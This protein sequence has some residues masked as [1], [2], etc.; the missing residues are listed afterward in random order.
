MKTLLASPRPG[1]TALRWSG[2]ASPIPPLGLASIA[3]CLREA[4][5]EVEILDLGVERLSGRAL[6]RR[7]GRARARLVGISIHTETRFESFALAR[8]V[9]LASP[10]AFI[11][12]GGPHATLAP[13]ETLTG[14][15]AFDAAV[16]GEGEETLVELARA[17]ESGRPVSSVRGLAFLEGGRYAETGRREGIDPLD[18]LPLP[19]RDLLPWDR[20][21]FSFATPEGERLPG[22]HLVTSRGCPH[23]CEFCAA[24]PLW[25]RRVR[26]RSAEKVIEELAEL[27][28]RWGARAFWFYDDT[29][30][31][32]RAR[33]EAIA[34]GMIESKLVRPWFCEIRAEG[35]D[36]ELLSLMREAGCRRVGLG[37]ESA[38][39]ELVRRVKG[40][41]ASVERSREVLAW[42]GELGIRAHP[43]FILSLPGETRAQ[44]EETLA[45]AR[46]CRAEGHEPAVSVLHVYPGTPLEARA[47]ELGILAPGFRWSDPGARGAFLLPGAQGNVPVW[48]DRLPAAA[49]QEMLGRYARALD[50]P[51]WRCG[52]RALARGGSLRPLAR[53]AAGWLGR[54]S[55]RPERPGARRLARAWLDARG[56]RERASG[57]PVKL[58]VEITSRCNLRCPRCPQSASPPG[59][60]AFMDRTLYSR[61]LREAM[62]F[63]PRVAL[64]HRGE[65]LLHPEALSMIAEAG[66]RGLACVLH[67][68]ATT[69]DREAARALLASG[70]EEISVSFDGPGRER[71]ERARAGASYDEVLANVRALLDEAARQP[72][73]DRPRIAVES[74]LA[75]GDAGRE[76]RLARE[77]RAE[78]APGRPDAVRLKAAHNWAGL[79]GGGANGR[80]RSRC[81]MPWTALVVLASGR[82]TACPQDFAAARVVGDL[83]EESLLGVWNGAPLRVLRREVAAGRLT[84]PCTLCDRPRRPAFLGVPLEA[85]GRAAREGRCP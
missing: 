34:R 14:A 37:V 23:G 5:V 75:R 81:L 62:R 84:P 64:H 65:S 30:T 29:F 78:L 42:C 82:V 72:R 20:Y 74:I 43:F 32:S 76:R 77:I 70:L 41:G 67:T 13:A 83:A 33:V 36:R 55:H 85:L 49:I 73:G 66:E 8:A 51:V 58:W 26:A 22:A 31:A 40:R 28:G 25:G 57:A 11:V 18:R 69:L 35:V 46:A 10:T 80:P 44:A 52:A 1:Y 53:S 45:M 68:N 9:R 38:S 7:I 2:G 63:S 47:R 3:A 59:G 12:C 4:G 16:L 39:A 21:R 17:L 48:L 60:A 27:A 50:L 24:A 56:G 54:A 15:G 19:A 71:Y 79:A 61:V 6:A